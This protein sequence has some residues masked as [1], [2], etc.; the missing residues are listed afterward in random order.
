VRAKSLG[1]RALV[2]LGAAAAAPAS[3][4]QLEPRAYSPSP[5]GANFFGVG[6][7]HS[8]GDVVFDPSL[9]F[10]DVSA[11]VNA[12][13]P[14]YA[15]TFGLFGRSASFG[16]VLPYA[17]G[18]VEG[19][20]GETFRRA[21]R[22]GLGDAG[23]RLACNLI[24]TPA[25]SPREF[26][27]RKP[28]AT[29]GASL[30]ITA[31][32]GEYDGSKLINLGSNRW[33]FKPELGY[34]QPLGR[35]WLDIYAGVWLFT[36]NHDFYGGQT[37]AQDPLAVAQGHVGYTFRPRLWLALNATWYRGGATTVDG[38]ANADRQ[39]NSRVGLTLA[40]PVSR[41]HSLKFGYA[42]GTSVRV[43]SKLDTISVAW[44]FLWF[45]KPA[46]SRAPATAP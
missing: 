1:L 22:S 23:L 33:A 45:D 8:S 36:T 42:K 29:L 3:A 14:F 10:S 40:V 2:L 41:T 46:A 26:A 16:A 7:A 35:W 11:H 17:W 4:Q 34:S 19:N 20:V 38:I 25:L 15:H 39:E 21:T 44:Q 31:P 32:T 28:S 37:R 9:P 24:G 43:G 18:T 12:V 6:Y 5:V 13:A 30:T 27:A